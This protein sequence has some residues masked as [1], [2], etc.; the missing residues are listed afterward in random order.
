MKTLHR[1]AAGLLLALSLATTG[2]A[3]TQTQF[4]TAPWGGFAPGRVQ[5]GWLQSVNF[6]STADQIIPISVPSLTYMLDAIT[7]DNASISLTTA[8][9]GFYTA[10]SK[11]GVAV[12]AN[13]QAYTT[14]TAA[15]VGAA[16]SAMSA[17]IATDGATNALPRAA[18]LYFSLTT[19]QGAAA[20]AD[21]RVFCRPLY[22]TR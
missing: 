9:G 14:L 20:T 11:G 12:V 3:Q 1:L 13:T 2:A 6:N 16:G 17:T 18:P 5:C 8:Q 10:E 22:P 7:I 15:A 21:I 19:G 4:P